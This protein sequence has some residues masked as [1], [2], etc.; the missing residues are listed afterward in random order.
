MFPHLFCSAFIEYVSKGPECI[1][2]PSGDLA[3]GL[4]AK[5]EPA[6]LLPAGACGEGPPDSPTERTW[7]AIPGLCLTPELL[8]RTDPD[9]HL[10]ADIPVQP[11]PIPTEV[12]SA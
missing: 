7:S 5:T 3:A 2:L 4:G 1:V 10:L 8:T 6:Q 11:R 12:P 9:P